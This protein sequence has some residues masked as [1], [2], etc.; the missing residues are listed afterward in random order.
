MSLAGG[1]SRL[2]CVE[3]VDDV[4]HV[5]TAWAARI[6]VACPSAGRTSIGYM[7]SPAIIWHGLFRRASSCSAPLIHVPIS[8]T[9]LPISLLHTFNI[10]THSISMPILI[11]PNQRTATANATTTAS[12]G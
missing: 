3:E 4:T 11:L 9:R 12:T 2:Q 1:Q 8:T 10:A 7:S 6:S 5:Y